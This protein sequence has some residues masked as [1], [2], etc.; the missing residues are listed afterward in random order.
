MVQRLSYGDLEAERAQDSKLETWS[1]LAPLSILKREEKRII[2]GYASIDVIDRQN[3]RIRLPALQR[4][5]ERFIASPNFA[6]IHV[7]HGNC[8]IGKPVI[9]P[10]V[11][12][13]GQKWFSHVDKVGLM[14]V[15]ELRDDLEYA[16]QA[17]KLIEQ[18]RLK[19]FSI[20]GQVLK[21]KELICE[22]GCHWEIPEL[23]IHEISIVDVPAVKGADFIIVKRGEDAH[24][25]DLLVGL[26][27]RI[28]VF[29]DY[30]SLVGSTSE[31]GEGKDFDLLVRDRED[32][33]LRRH[34]ETLFNKHYPGL[35]E[36]LDWIWGDPQGPHD[37]HIPLYD[38]CLVRREPLEVVQ[39]QSRE[40]KLNKLRKDKRIRDKEM[41]GEESGTAVAP[42]AAPEGSV[43][44]SPP[45]EKQAPT[46]ADPLLL[47]IKGMLEKLLNMLEEQ[48]AKKPPEEE[49]E[50][51]KEKAKPK[52]EKYPYKDKYPDKKSL[53]DWFAKLADTLGEESALV[54]LH[55]LG[56]EAEKLVPVDQPPA[57]E[58]EGE[59]DT[60]TK[61]VGA[62][63]EVKGAEEIMAEMKAAIASEVEK[64]LLERLPA[65]KVVK[66]T[67]KVAI[68]K[69]P[70]FED[71][72]GKSWNEIH[73]LAGGAGI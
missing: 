26:H 66:R 29:R 61:E 65:G 10:Y 63:G 41:T 11:D 24:L 27:D 56:P 38:L 59:E 5:W 21:P 57:E 73:R 70:T 34:I 42:P 37:Q 72:F 52:P 47:E 33:Q 46:Q 7:L 50:E 68:T 31:K 16:N 8:P 19:S 1:F 69:E 53:P 28:I 23:E 60:G 39:M 58:G 40:G 44:S 55:V 49:E 15:C 51:D 35:W 4:A 2:A 71:L 22:D 67:P 12:A 45:A 9:K 14:L 48:K 18:G 32:S 54:T 13:K 17:W 30:I 36:K 6:N 20:G 3:E 43:P 64:K 25:A 62:E